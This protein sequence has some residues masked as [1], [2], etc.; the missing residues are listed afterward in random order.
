MTERQMM[1]RFGENLQYCME[2]AC[3]NQ[4][5]LAEASRLSPSAIS[6][7]LR[8]ERMPTLKSINNLVVALECSIDNLVEVNWLVE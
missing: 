2:E 5:E 6:Y 8:G 1:R 4:I 7:Y 3:M